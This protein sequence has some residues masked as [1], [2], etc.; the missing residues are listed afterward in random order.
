MLTHGSTL[1]EPGNNIPEA[2]PARDPKSRGTKRD[3]PVFRLRPA[4][5]PE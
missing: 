4:A 5:A 3:H 1:R 2:R